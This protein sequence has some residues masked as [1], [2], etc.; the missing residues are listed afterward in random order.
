MIK[1]SKLKDTNIKEVKALPASNNISKNGNNS[2]SPEFRQ[3]VLDVW[4]SGA[5]AS[6]PDCAKSYGVKESTLYTWISKDKYKSQAPANPDF[7]SLKQENSRLKM[8]LEILKKAAIYFAAH[9][10]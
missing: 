5:Y 4:N 6:V 2:Y 3:Q 7:V 10:K 9:A 1:K 8:E